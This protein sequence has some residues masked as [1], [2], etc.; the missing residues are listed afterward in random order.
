MPLVVIGEICGDSDPSMKLIVPWMKD[1]G[2]GIRSVHDAGLE[3][4]AKAKEVALYRGE[5]EE[6]T[7]KLIGRKLYWLRKR[8]NML[9]FQFAERLNIP[10]E[11]YAS[12]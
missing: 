9:L 11:E 10:E 3:E 1:E 8:V 5:S 6:T 7:W 2:I 12:L 4:G